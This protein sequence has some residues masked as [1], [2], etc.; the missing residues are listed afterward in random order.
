MRPCSRFGYCIYAILEKADFLQ[1]RT[2]AIGGETD[3]EDEDE[4]G[5]TGIAV[6]AKSTNPYDFDDEPGLLSD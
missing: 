4:D 1:G 6:P 5:T 2:V 3:D